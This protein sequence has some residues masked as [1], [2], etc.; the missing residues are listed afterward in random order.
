MG[1][2]IFRV[3]IK[4]VSQILKISQQTFWQIIGKA[5]SVISTIIILGLITRKFGE[6]GTGIFTLALTYI[7]MFM[8]L[9]D[10]GFNAHVLRQIRNVRQVEPPRGTKFEIRNEFRKLLG[11][12]IVWA[13]V[14]MV[15]SVS[16]L[17]FLPV[18]GDQFRQMIILG[19]PIIFGSAIFVSC[20]LIFQSKLRYDLSVSATSAGTVLNLL[21]VVWFVNFNFPLLYLILAQILNWMLVVL[22][23]LIL[24]QKIIHS[25]KPIFD[26]SFS[27]KL[28]K[29]SWPIA[30]TLGLN[31]VYFRADSFIV[32]YF[33][34]VSDTGIY[35]IA[36]SIFQSALV[37]PAFI[38][39]AYYPMMLKSFKGIRLV[40]L[41]LFV[42]AGFGTLL[43]LLLAP[44]V[45]KILT[46]SGFAGSS[47]ALQ[48]LS[49]GF[50]AYFLSALLMWTMVTKGMYKKLLFIYASGLLINLAL[51][52]IFIPQYSFY[53]ASVI[54]V[55]SEYL[56]LILLA[57][58]LRL[59][60]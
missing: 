40:G 23:A 32:A 4:S 2:V 44:F 51:N 34:G 15:I 54:T 24:S 52:F 38:M 58:S 14:L 59:I 33:K 57:A 46:G 13:A 3:R 56:I 31:V 30:A 55:I 22:L 28:I 50:P 19:S 7:S 35:N 12:R 45:I 37:L 47:Q 27:K 25:L 49:L 17:P 9:A 48:I 29:S 60:K 53:G 21:L 20:N 36:Y 5:I 8:L 1:F 6:Q 18:G 43:T 42:L 11:T 41:G 26:I 39:N 16:L 10:F